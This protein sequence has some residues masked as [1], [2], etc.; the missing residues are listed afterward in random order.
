VGGLI[1]AKTGNADLTFVQL[2]AL[3]LT[4]KKYLDLFTTGTN[5]TAQ[6]TEIFSYSTTPDMKLRTAVH[7]SISIPLYF[8]AVL[9]DEQGR[10]VPKPKRSDS[11]NVM[12]DGGIAANYPIDVFDSGRKINPAT[13]GLKL[14]RPEQIEG[15]VQG[16]GIAA[17]PIGGMSGYVG[18]RYNFMI[19]KLNRDR[20]LS[21]EQGRTIYISTKG[22][23]PRVKAMNRRDKLLLYNSGRD[24]ATAFF[25]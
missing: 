23:R 15:Y 11:Y 1:L 13:L 22:I 8:S 20:D 24:A 17:F 6:R 21:N 16:T 14:E 10:V 2:H 5:L 4:N 25:K 19:E 12:I 3:H 18:A 9:L 7:I